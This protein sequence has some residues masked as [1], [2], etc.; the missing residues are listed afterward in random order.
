MYLILETI[1]YYYYNI[2]V[3]RALLDIEIEIELKNTSSFL[4]LYSRSRSNSET[5]PRF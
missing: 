2:L 1:N 5:H 3:F 4:G